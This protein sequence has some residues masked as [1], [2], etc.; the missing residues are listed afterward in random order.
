M[1]PTQPARCPRRSRR[2]AASAIAVSLALVAAACGGD[3]DD[4]ADPATATTDAP[5]VTT[6]SSSSPGATTTAAATGV[7]TGSSSLPGP[8]TTAAAPDDVDPDGVLHIGLDLTATGGLDLDPIEMDSP[9]DFHVHYNIYDTLLRQH[10]DGSYEPGLAAS[11]KI[12]NP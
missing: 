6:G 8:T 12:T 2:L 5:A 11:A 3:D 10:E 4:Q 9:T 1:R 7:T